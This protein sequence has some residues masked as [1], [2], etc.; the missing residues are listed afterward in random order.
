MPNNTTRSYLDLNGLRYYNGKLNDTFDTKVSKAAGK[1]LSTNDYTDEDQSKL[2]NIESGSQKNRIETV[3]VNG[4]TQPVTQ[5][6]VNLTVPTNNNQLTNGAGY[7][8]ASDVSGAIAMAISNITSFEHSVVSSL[9]AS[10][11]KG[12]IYLVPH[13]HDTGDGYDEYVWVNNAFEKLGHTDVIAITNAEIDA[14]FSQGG[15]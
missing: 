12:T 6:N 7:Q 10:G 8:T 9:P 2:A 14:M 13:S 3:S 15:D 11:V 5:K 1:G 4:V